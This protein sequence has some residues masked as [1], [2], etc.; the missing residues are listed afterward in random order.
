M[1]K[2]FKKHFSKPDGILG[3]IAG[4]I[5]ALE[6]RKLNA[7][8]VSL[9]G[10]KSHDHILEIGYGSGMCMERILKKHT[11]INI[12]GVDVSETMRKQASKRLEDKIVNQQVHLMT[13]DI[14][15]ITLPDQAYDKI[16]TVNNYT[17]WDHPKKGLENVFG[18]LKSN[19]KIAITMQPREEN[20]SSAKTRMFAKQIF[21]DLTNCSFS[22]IKI[23]FKRI[24]PELSVCVT[25][26]KLK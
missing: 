1:M 8:T 3:M 14:V 16:I 19:G 18:A 7:W 21:N 13:G 6:N 20:A 2:S 15:E 12:D 17:I 24:R 5:M 26:V 9:L 22:N 4:R 23:H 10:L 11:N 25:A